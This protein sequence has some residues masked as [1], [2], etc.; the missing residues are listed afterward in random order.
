[1]VVD[2]EACRTYSLCRSQQAGCSERSWP[3]R[4]ALLRARVSTIL[5]SVRVLPVHLACSTYKLNSQIIVRNTHS[6][7]SLTHSLL[8]TPASRA[9]SFS[10]GSSQ[11]TWSR[12]A[13]RRHCASGHGANAWGPLLRPLRGARGARSVVLPA[14]GMPAQALLKGHCRTAA[15][16]TSCSHS[17]PEKKG[18]ERNDPK[19][20][21]LIPDC[22]LPDYVAS[23][24]IM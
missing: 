10:Y 14:R 3:W 17:A 18:R 5:L 6:T 12:P 2:E 21:L 7:R 9:C 15:Q 16:R 19:Y 22:S 13:H 20:R 1:M 24:S 23:E 4:S 11:A 8:K